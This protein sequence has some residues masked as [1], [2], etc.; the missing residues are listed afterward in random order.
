MNKFIYKMQYRCLNRKKSGERSKMKLLT[1]SDLDCE[2][3]VANGV[4]I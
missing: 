2:E 3:S 1:C 4:E